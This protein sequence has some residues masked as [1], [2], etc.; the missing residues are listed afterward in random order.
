MKKAIVSRRISSR[1]NLNLS[2]GFSRTYDGFDKLLASFGISGGVPERPYF[3]GGYWDYSDE[4]QDWKSF[5]D[6]LSHAKALL[7]IAENIRDEIAET[8]RLQLR[9]RSRNTT[10]ICACVKWARDSQTYRKMADMFEQEYYD[11]DEEWESILRDYD[12]SLSWHLAHAHDIL[13]DCRAVFVGGLNEIFVSDKEE[14]E[15]NY[16]FRGKCYYL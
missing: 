5:E 2:G 15:R 7:V 16:T 12:W 13:V 1:M 9:D 6:K 3:N 14:A 4:I 8:C 11:D 10:K